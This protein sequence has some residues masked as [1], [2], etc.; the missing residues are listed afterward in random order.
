MTTKILFST[1][2]HF[3][4]VS[5]VVRKF[6]GSRVSHAA[7]LYWD[8]DFDMDMV[9]EAHELGFR[10]TPLKHFERHNQIVKLAVPKNVIDVGLK[11]VANRY[12]GS[13]YDYAGLIGMA[14]VMFGR[15]LKRKWKNPFRGAKSVYCSEAV[16][17]AMKASPGYGGLDLDS[18]SSPQDLL[19]YFEKNEAV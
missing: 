17:L 13:M 15:F 14:V 7:F 9:M 3:N 2:K 5:W 6:T 18:D 8:T 19:E 1:P 10:L 4:P 16:I 12:L 11:V